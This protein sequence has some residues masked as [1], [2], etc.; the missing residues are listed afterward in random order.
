MRRRQTLYGEP[1]ASACISTVN[2]LPVLT[3]FARPHTLRGSP[4]RGGTHSPPSA[5]SSPRRMGLHPAVS[6]PSLLLPISLPDGQPS[7][8]PSPL[9]PLRY[10]PLPRRMGCRPRSRGACGQ[11]LS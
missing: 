4:R 9:I 2:A 10:P 7:Y 1:A 6:P 3:P 11:M 5:L 8:R